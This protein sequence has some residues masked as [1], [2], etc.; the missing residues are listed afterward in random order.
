MVKGHKSCSEDLTHL[1]YKPDTRA[2]VNS[3]W[4]IVSFGTSVQRGKNARV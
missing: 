1:T 4:E 3:L 2:V